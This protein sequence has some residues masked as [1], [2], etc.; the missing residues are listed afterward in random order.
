MRVAV[1]ARPSPTELQMILSDLEMIEQ[2]R[3]SKFRFE[4]DRD[5]AAV[6]RALL[7]H[8]KATLFPNPVDSFSRTREGKPFVVVHASM[9]LTSEVSDLALHVNISHHG[10]WVVGVASDRLIGVDVMT[11]DDIGKSSLSDFFFDMNRC[12]TP[13]EWSHIRRGNPLQEFFIRWCLKEAYIKATGIGLGQ[14]LQVLPTVA[15]HI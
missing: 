6:G 14:D 3:I 7:L 15:P 5:R 2:L 11:I 9:S 10:D 12:F 13:R 8:M 4:Q 1:L